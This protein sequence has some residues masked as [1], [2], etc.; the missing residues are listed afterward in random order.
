MSEKLN[1]NLSED[2]IKELKTF[3]EM[4]GFSREHLEKEVH[5]EQLTAGLER[6]KEI[7]LRCSEISK[8]LDKD[9]LSEDDINKLGEELEKLVK[10]GHENGQEVK[11]ITAIVGLD[12]E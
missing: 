5:S 8:T 7:S 12:E 4:D 2:I 6:V 10:E 3:K 11:R 9:N 1:N